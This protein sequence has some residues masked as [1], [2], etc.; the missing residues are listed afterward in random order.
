M[1][2]I[3]KIIDSLWLQYIKIL[4]F[5]WDCYAMHSPVINP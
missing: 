5:C 1:A 2:V 4:N 3:H